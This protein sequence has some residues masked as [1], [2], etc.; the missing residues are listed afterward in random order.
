MKLKLDTN[1]NVVLTDGK[2]TYVTDDGKD[3][4]ADVPEMY[5]KLTAAGNEAKTHRT[6]ADAAEAKLAE[7]NGIDAKAAKAA[8]QTVKDIKDG[9]LI[10]KGEVE[11][12]R[13]EIRS[14]FE[15]QIG[16]LTETNASLTSRLNDTRI[17][18]AFAN[19]AY[20][21]DKL[22][23]PHDMIRNQFGASF[24]FNDKDT[25]EARDATGNVIFSKARPGEHA[26]FE[27]A[28]AILVEA[29]PH[30]N[31]IL[32]GANNAGSGNKGD[33]GNQGNKRTMR[34]SEWEAM[35]PIPKAEFA[36]AVGKG[37]AAFAE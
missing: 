20:I 23:L 33:G 27:E 35:Q 9:D 13:Q 37:E 12:V 4:V 14:S 19:S 8:L 21:K 34:R 17:G 30:K 26:D 36:A 31:T 11:R 15:G 10:N 18:N 5:S 7:F 2:P 3:F 16:T 6:R 24:K 22:T 28:M 32:K 25:L 1:G 29:Y